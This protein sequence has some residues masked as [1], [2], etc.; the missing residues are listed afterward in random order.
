MTDITPS[1]EPDDKTF[2]AVQRV[3]SEISDYLGLL[4]KPAAGQLGLIAFDQVQHWRL[5]NLTRLTEKV[6]RSERKGRANP[7]LAWA[8][9]EQAT[10]TDDDGLLDMWA[11]LLNSSRGEN[12]TDT[13]ISFVSRLSQMSSTQA[14]ILNYLCVHG[15]KSR[16]GSLLMGRLVPEPLSDHKFFGSMDPVQLDLDLDHLRSLGLIEGGITADQA[17]SIL[18]AP[19]ALG[20]YMYVRCIGSGLAP[21]DYF[22]LDPTVEDGSKKS[23]DAQ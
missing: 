7:R 15:A 14:N 12:P 10:S 3:V 13:N 16:H 2:G 5:R 1:N 18:V 6:K 21:V 19:S 20:L 22:I 9:L 17:N 23:T 11:G 8:I 4:F